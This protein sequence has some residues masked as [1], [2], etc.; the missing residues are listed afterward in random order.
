[1]HQLGATTINSFIYTN[2]R[3]LD[4][5]FSPILEQ[6]TCLKKFPHRQAKPLACQH[7]EKISRE[8]Q[9]DYKDIIPYCLKPTTRWARWDSG[10]GSPSHLSVT[11][12]VPAFAIASGEMIASSSFFEMKLV[13]SGSPFSMTR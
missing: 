9:S 1:M 7:L 5:D 13:G 8:V 3:G 6:K 2:L 4:F 11:M 12:Y 10:S